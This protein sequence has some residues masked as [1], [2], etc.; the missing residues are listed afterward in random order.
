MLKERVIPKAVLYFTGEILQSGFSSEVDESS[1]DDSLSGDE[2]V[3]K[4]N[5]HTHFNQDSDSENDSSKH[6]AGEGVEKPPECDK[7]VQ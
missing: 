5:K 3:T 2:E 1:G 4:A 7:Q 6:A